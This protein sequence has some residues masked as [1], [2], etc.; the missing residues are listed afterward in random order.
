MG[1]RSGLGKR[2][3]EAAEA[4]SAQAGCE[5]LH[6]DFDEVHTRFYIDICGFTPAPAGIKHLG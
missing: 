6:V 2:L 3:V 4:A 5:W 1:K